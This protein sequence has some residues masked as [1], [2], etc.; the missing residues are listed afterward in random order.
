MLKLDEPLQLP[1]IL[2]WTGEYKINGAV[3][4]GFM[5]D[6]RGEKLYVAY[7]FKNEEEKI[8]FE[9]YS[10]AGQQFFVYG[11]LQPPS[12]PAHRYGFSMARYLKSK[13]A[14]GILEISE[15]TYVGQ[16]KNALQPLYEQ[17]FKLKRHIEQYFPE[18]LV[19]EAQALII[20][21]QEN[22]DD[23]LNRAY[24][25]LGITHLFAISGLHVA[26]VSLLFFQ[27]LLRLGVRRELATIILFIVLPMY[28]ILAGGAPSVWRAVSVVE[29]VMLTQYL[30]LKI[31]ID[32]AIA[33][34]FIVFVFIEPGAVF[35]IGFQLS[36]LA[37]LSIIYSGRIVTRYQNWWIQSFFITF[38]CQ[39]LVYPLL[40]YH[41]FEISISSFINEH[42]FCSVIFICYFTDEYFIANGDVD[43]RS[44]RNIAFRHL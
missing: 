14:R 43:S 38:V 19:A 18:T 13:N 35:Q 8:R 40:L 31:P 33:I 29:L 7:T 4:R 37:T 17:R 11:E 30:R 32:D 36:Y 12:V 10:L 9:Q 6:K 41:F 44:S 20:G 3:V 24:Q 27:S 15:F 25:K 21:M 39:I 5:K 26:L 22:V 2:T 34:S 23:E 16:V 1:A 42:P 28:A